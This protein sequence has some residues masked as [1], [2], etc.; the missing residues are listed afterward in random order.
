MGA[1]IALRLM[2]RERWVILDKEPERRFNSE[3]ASPPLARMAKLVNAPASDAGVYTALKV[4]V[5]LRAFFVL[6]AIGLYAMVVP[7]R[8][9]TPTQ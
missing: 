3:W 6:T 4:R 8:R 5:F 2:Y 7:A 1:L 9:E